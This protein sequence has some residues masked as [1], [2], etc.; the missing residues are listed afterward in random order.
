MIDQLVNYEIAE[1]TRHFGAL[2]ATE[3]VDEKVKEACNKNLLK[4]VNALN[5]N[6]DKA[7]AANQTSNSGLIK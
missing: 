1:F 3:G 6:V 2:V 7:I 4:L 5:I